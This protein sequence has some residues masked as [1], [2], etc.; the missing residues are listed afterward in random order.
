MGRHGSGWPAELTVDTSGG[1]RRKARARVGSGSGG[2]RVG[3]GVTQ[4]ERE[5]VR[6]EGGEG[7]GG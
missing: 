1:G 5:D 3:W 6:K 4:N 2:E 7:K